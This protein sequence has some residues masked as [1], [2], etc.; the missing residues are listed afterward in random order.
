MGWVLL[1]VSAET[2]STEWVLLNVTEH[3]LLQFSPAIENLNARIFCSSVDL[4]DLYELQSAFE[5]KRGFF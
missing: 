1:K 2:S 4:S 3:F 5:K